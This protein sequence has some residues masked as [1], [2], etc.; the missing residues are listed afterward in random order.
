MGDK[1]KDPKPQ[2]QLHWR[3]MNKTQG[4][5]KKAAFEPMAM[6]SAAILLHAANPQGRHPNMTAN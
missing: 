4:R 1:D 5:L 6:S 2:A 3:G